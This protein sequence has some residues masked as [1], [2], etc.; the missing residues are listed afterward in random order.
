MVDV[1]PTPVSQRRWLRHTVHGADRWSRRQPPPDGRWQRG[2]VVE[3]FYLAN[4][5]ATVWA[6]WYR[7]LAEAGI[8]PNQQM[9]RDLWTW[10]VEPGLEVADLTTLERLNRL[11]LGL[12][13]PGCRTWPA[14]QEVGEALWREGWSGLLAPSAARP[15]D[16]LVLCLFRESDEDLGVRPVPP[17][18]VVQ[19]PPVPPTGM[20]T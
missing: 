20:T 3:A 1:D 12:P 4:D 14:Y 13:R 19:E 17:P 15:R 8:P 2:A 9:P 6:E 5:E 11:G 16:G 18:R 10:Q 7:H